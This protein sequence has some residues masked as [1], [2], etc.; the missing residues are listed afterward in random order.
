MIDSHVGY[1]GT[2]NPACRSLSNIS[3]SFFLLSTTMSTTPSQ[4][5]P[6]RSPS[7]SPDLTPLKESELPSPQPEQSSAV[8]RYRP[9][10]STAHR[11][12]KGRYITSND[13]RGYM[14]VFLT[15]SPSSHAN[16]TFILDARHTLA[17]TD[18]FTNTPLMA[19]G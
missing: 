16:P 4:V 12:T 17:S 11:V 10:P 6:S 13:P 7:V 18:P 3:L 19:N 5:P 15:L 1:P 14:S 9:F 8:S 2:E